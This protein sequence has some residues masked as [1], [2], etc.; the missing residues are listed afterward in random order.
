MHHRVYALD[1]LDRIGELHGFTSLVATERDL[2]S[3]AWS[4]ELPAGEGFD[5]ADRLAA[6]TWPGIEIVSDDGAARF[7]GPMLVDEVT[8]SAEGERRRFAGID[9]Q[10]RA[11]RV[12]EQP[13]PDNDQ[14]WWSIVVG[15]TLPRTTDLHNMM[16]AQ[17][18]PGA[19]DHRK[20]RNLQL[21]DDPAAGDPL[22]RR[23]KG[24][25]LLEVWRDLLVGTQWTARL[26]LVR[27]TS[28]SAA[29]R[30][31]TFA[32]PVATTV[33][34]ARTGTVDQITWTRAA[35]DHSKVIVMGAE[36]DP[37]PEPGARWVDSSYF[38][39]TSWLREYGELFV[40]RPQADNPDTVLAELD[41]EIMKVVATD[42]LAVFGAN[43]VGWGTDID[44]GWRVDVRARA[45]GVSTT[46]RLPV[47]ASTLRFTADGGWTR[48]VDLGEWRPSQPLSLMEQLA[49]IGRRLRLLEGEV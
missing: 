23:I 8:E 3:G 13:V 4:V 15:G 27:P 38:E 37:P 17:C 29:V 16:Y 2:A 48:K 42:S 25:P 1:D 20:M 46:V 40:N 35:P 47:V 39:P 12:L 19:Q 11:A 30:F 41:T 7:A 10:G 36:K 9:F 6:A 5:V 21:G 43:P 32:R 26:R 34:D 33:L 45:G 49:Q 24:Q 28:T 22:D 31:D 18:G 44:L 14:R